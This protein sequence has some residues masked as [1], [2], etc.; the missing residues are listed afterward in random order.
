[1]NDWSLK[2]MNSKK[3]F[4]LLI[5]RF[6][7]NK[8]SSSSWCL[9]PLHS[10]LSIA[11]VSDFS[12]LILHSSLRMQ[13]YLYSVRFRS[14]PLAIKLM[15]VF[16]FALDIADSGNLINVMWDYLIRHFG[17]AAYSNT[18]SRKWMSEVSKETEFPQLCSICISVVAWHLFCF[19]WFLFL[20]S[21]IRSLPC[22]YWKEWCHSFVKPSSATECTFTTPQDWSLSQSWSLLLSPFCVQSESELL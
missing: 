14:D 8:S 15:V 12:I 2:S 4:Q 21:Q 1:M 18:A 22:Q 10:L 13:A 9:P 3:N 11:I 16:L 19:K 7:R 17:D 5:R 20:N 6:F